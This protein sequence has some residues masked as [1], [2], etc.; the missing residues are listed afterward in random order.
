MDAKLDSI[1][2][3]IAMNTKDWPAFP[4]RQESGDERRDSRA[5]A[6]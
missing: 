3:E 6:R 2:H 5:D 4:M 1:E